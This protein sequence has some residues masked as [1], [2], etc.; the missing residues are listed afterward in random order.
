M[1][2]GL[3]YYQKIIYSQIVEK[4][5]RRK[6]TIIDK[7]ILLTIT[8]ITVQFH[9]CFQ[10]IIKVLKYSNLIFWNSSKRTDKMYMYMCYQVK[11]FRY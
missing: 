8:L 6:I 4:Y 5:R 7:T 2:F 3:D 11:F 9:K 10:N 1:G